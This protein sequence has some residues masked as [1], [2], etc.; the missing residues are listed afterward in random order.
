[1]ID[2]LTLKQT[3]LDIAGQ[4][5]PGLKEATRQVM[6]AHRDTLVKE[7]ENAIIE[8]EARAAAKAARR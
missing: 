6:N 2:D 1:M 4:D 8:K 7:F 3:G 5:F